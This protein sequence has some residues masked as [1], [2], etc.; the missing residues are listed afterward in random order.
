MRN[1][2]L[3]AEL[4]ELSAAEVERRLQKLSG[5]PDAWQEAGGAGLATALCLAICSF[6]GVVASLGLITAEKT[7][8]QDPEAAL[9][10]DV[11]PLIGCGK[12][13]G[14][15]QNEIFFGISNSVWGLAAFSALFMLA[16]VLLARGRFHSLLWRVLSIGA[17]GGLLW[18]IWFVYESFFV[19]GTICPY[20][21][22]VWLATIPIIVLLISRSL[23]GGHWG[24]KGRGVGQFLVRNRFLCVFL[25]YGILIA[26]GIFQLGGKF[27]A[28]F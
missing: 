28:L 19:S 16:L 5:A 6:L 23:Q 18:I 22:I 20:C 13:I 10:C 14:T 9:V 24:D 1:K 15:W 26:L 7:H 4:E 11:N 21:F 12:W 27:S 8:L 2:D 3:D 25:L 17:V